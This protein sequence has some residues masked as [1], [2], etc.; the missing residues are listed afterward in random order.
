MGDVSP[1][2]HIVTHEAI[3]EQLA[4]SDP[5]EVRAAYERLIALGHD[6]H[7]VR[8]ALADAL[9]R[10]VWRAQ[11]EGGPFDVGRYATALAAMPDPANDAEEETLEPLPPAR[12]Q[13]RDRERLRRLPRGTRAW[14]GDL[15]DLPVEIEGLGAPLCAVWA[16]GD[17]T[18][19]AMTPEVDAEPGQLVLIAFVR[20]ALRPQ[21]GRAELPTRVLVHPEIASALRGPLGEVRVIVEEAD[22]L[23]LAH[24]ALDALADHLV[25][26]P[27]SRPRRRRR[28]GH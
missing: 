26:S 23:P 15:T 17:G 28:R 13:A 25:R 11:S 24:E 27:G 9:A 7:A 3:A 4:A 21:I 8:H 19:R 2:A 12:L 22:D 14:E 6:E 10:E 1:R 16:D 5:P 18:I 20:A